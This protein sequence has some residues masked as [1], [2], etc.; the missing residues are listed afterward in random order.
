MNDSFFFFFSLRISFGRTPSS[1]ILEV[2]AH[3][4]SHLNR[5]MTYFSN[6]LSQYVDPLNNNN[7]LFRL[8]V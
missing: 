6:A 7:I 3:I 4:S 1:S 8:I 5:E 2:Y